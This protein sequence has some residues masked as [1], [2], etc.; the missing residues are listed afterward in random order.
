MQQPTGGAELIGSNFVHHLVEHT[1]RTRFEK[2][3]E[4]EDASTALCRYLESGRP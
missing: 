3:G 1:L 4:P 2:T